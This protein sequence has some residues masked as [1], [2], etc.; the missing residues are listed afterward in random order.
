MGNKDRT[1]FGDAMGEG[2]LEDKE[3]FDLRTTDIVCLLDLNDSENLWESGQR[4]A[5]KDSCKKS[6]EKRAWCLAANSLYML[7]VPDRES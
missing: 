6:T 5:P 7:C 3:L 1:I 2:E 4:R